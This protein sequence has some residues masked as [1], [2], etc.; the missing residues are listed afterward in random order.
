ME[1]LLDALSLLRRRNEKVRLAV[2]GGGI[3]LSAPTPY[4][5]SLL[6]R[7]ERLGV[8]EDIVWTGEYDADSDVASRY[9]YSADACVLPFD[10]GVTL[11]RSSL[12]AVATHGLPI[13]S[14]RGDTLEAAFV[15]RENVYLCPPQDANAL[16][17]AVNALVADRALQQQ[18][19]RGAMELA[20]RWFSWE[21][22]LDVT[23][24]SFG[25]ARQGAA[26]AESVR[27]S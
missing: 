6:E 9:L 3:D 12:A 1:T 15:D 14:T 20:D 4:V 16:A 17:E 5:R 18:L 24:A 22:A 10:N 23:L 7:A 19:R 27:P 2:I 26:V 21:R 8:Q 13:V 11:N 25:S